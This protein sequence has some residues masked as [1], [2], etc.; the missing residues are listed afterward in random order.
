MP[1]LT[2]CF[3]HLNQSDKNMTEPIKNIKLQFSCPI[4]WESMESLDGA[5]YCHH[6]QKKVYDFSNTNQDEFLKILA[7][8]NGNL[9]GRYRKSQMAQRTTSLRNWKK[10]LSAATLLIGVNVVSIKVDAQ[11]SQH[12]VTDLKPPAKQPDIVVGGI[13]QELEKMPEFPGGFDRFTSF[14]TKNTRY[15]KKMGKGRVFVSFLVNKTGVLSDFKIERG[16]SPITDQEAL[17]VLKLSPK[18]T[19]AVQNGKPVP[20]RYIVPISFTN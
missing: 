14:I 12:P 8:N 9:C 20:L 15:S 19:P 7:Q 18:W 5:K 4:D 11:S 2:I 16:V 6:C 3:R 10:W 1:R 13:G 17:R